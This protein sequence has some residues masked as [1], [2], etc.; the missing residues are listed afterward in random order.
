MARVSQYRPDILT[1]MP[2]F[3][4]GSD[5]PIGAFMMRGATPATNNGELI[6]AAGTSA[7][8]DV[9]GILSELHDFSVTGDNLID[10]TAFVTL[11]VEIQS[12]LRIIRIEYDPTSLI[13]ATEAVNTTTIT[14]SS[15][16]NNIDAAFLYVFSGTGAGQTN[17]LTASGAG[18]A[19]LKAAFGTDL[20]T[21]SNLMKILPRFHQLLGL[22][23]AGTQ[24]SSQAAA[25]AVTGIVIDSFI[26]RGGHHAPLDPTKHDALTGLNNLSNIKFSADI[27]LTNTIPYAID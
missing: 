19:T 11:P 4:N 13:D 18:S 23:A 22:N 10:G 2:I 15:L 26:E 20:D 14:L 6:L 21:T 16:E 1:N 5:I 25:G 9:L 12:P 27:M 3:G 8:P 7:I 17:Y 24:L